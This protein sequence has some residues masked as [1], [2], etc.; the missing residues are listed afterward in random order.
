MAEKPLFIGFL[1]SPHASRLCFYET[2]FLFLTFIQ[3][4]E[5]RVASDENG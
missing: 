3:A 4:I 5:R 2:S 1:E